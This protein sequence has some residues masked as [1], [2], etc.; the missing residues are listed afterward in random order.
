M[1]PILTSQQ[2]R[3]ADQYTI[4]HEP[5]SSLALM[6]RASIAF[7]KQFIELCGRGKSI[8]VFCGTG[9]NG[10]DGL[11]VSRLLKEKGFDITTYIIGDQ[12]K[13]SPDFLSNLDRLSHLVTI[14][15]IQKEAHFPELNENNVAIDA[16][17]GSGLS[18]KIEGI[19][20]SIINHINHSGCEVYAIDIAS[21]LFSDA[22]IE[23]G[24]IIRPRHTI[25]FQVPKLA[26]FMPNTNPFVGDWHIV[27]IGLDQKFIQSQETFCYYSEVEDFISML[28]KRD[29]FM[30]KGKAGRIQIFAGKIG[31]MG[32]AILCAK[33]TLRTGSGLVYIHTPTNGRDVLQVTVPEAMVNS[34]EHQEIIT[35]I[36]PLSGINAV[37]IGP[38]IGTN[39][40]TSEAL[41][42]GLTKIK[43]PLVIDADGINI[44]AN[45][46]ESLLNLPQETILTPHPGE[47]ERL[48]GAWENDFEKTDRLR[49][50]CRKY[51]VNVVLKGAYSTVCSSTGE[52]HFN[53]S[54]NP[55]MATGG[56]GDVLTGIIVS[57]LGQGLNPFDALK[58]GVFIHGL[59]GDLGV[60]DK[61]EYSLI[62]SDIIDYLPNAFREIQSYRNF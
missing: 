14:K 10:G 55:G 33:A 44:L 59:S 54:G 49:N 47:F 32:A 6:E 8:F 4:Q 21:G 18:R 56:S 50:F 22:P 53:C 13:G 46:P 38:G 37:A 12:S 26:F 15:Y 57:F 34:D 42:K 45:H 30:H 40:E 1:K 2:I 16:M 58:L 25:S 23:G 27:D 41:R 20:A 61:G 39:K 19:F 52:I 3:E 62:A 7:V 9:N 51:K 11:A 36:E 28:P 17:F 29:T 31:S 48:V 35:Q 43:Y 60:K 24:A 5:I